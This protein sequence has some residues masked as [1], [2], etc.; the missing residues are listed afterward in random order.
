MN[1]TLNTS[2]FLPAFAMP[3]ELALFSLTQTDHDLFIYQDIMIFVSCLHRYIPRICMLCFSLFFSLPSNLEGHEERLR[4][5]SVFLCK[6]YNMKMFPKDLM[7]LNKRQS[8]FGLLK[9][10]TFGTHHVKSHSSP[11][12]RRVARV[13]RGNMKKL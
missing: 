12:H 8:I 4:I 1:G 13:F 2:I 6:I 7:G 9:S 3:L 10:H 5:N 11:H